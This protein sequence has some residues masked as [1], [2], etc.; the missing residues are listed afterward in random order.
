[1][2][3][4][5][6]QEYVRELMRWYVDAG[7]DET[8][9]D[10]AI[11]RFA[12]NIQV[13]NERKLAQEELSAAEPQN[14]VGQATTLHPSI[15]SKGAEAAMHDA[16]HLAA[17]ANTIDELRSVVENFDGCPL[18]KTATNLVFLDGNTES[19]ILIIGG[20]PGADEDRQGIP[21]SGQNGQL[22]DKMMASIGLDRTNVL[23]GG[24]VFWRPPGNR[25]PTQAEISVCMPFVERL[26]EL[27]DPHIV[28]AMGETAAKVLMAQ[29]KAIGRLRGKWVD[30][31]LPGLPR[32]IDLL[33]MNS[34]K[35]LLNS[36][37]QKR[38]AW[39]DL[40]LIKKKL[41]EYE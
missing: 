10:I 14:K 40:L 6:N 18:K 37:I 34:P 22:F 35:V 9:A 4:L 8:I 1:M 17:S 24:I 36:P 29:K 26:I 7:V 25:S 39:H 30:Y 19:R 13:I 15:P 16:V 38:D 5:Q 31:S 32:P 3:Q 11:D 12:E 41:I 20:A 21:F 28:I 33:A 27:V 2:M 23:I